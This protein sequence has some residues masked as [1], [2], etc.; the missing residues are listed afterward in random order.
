MTAI[1]FCQKQ[2]IEILAVYIIGSVAVYSAV[3]GQGILQIAMS[4]VQCVGNEASLLECAYSES[5]CSHSNDAGVRC[6]IRTSKCTDFI[7]K[8][9]V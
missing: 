2:S 7:L 8:A 1:K 5:S 3:F 4:N 9:I 6:H